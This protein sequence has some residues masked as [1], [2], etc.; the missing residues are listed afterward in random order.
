VGNYGTRQSYEKSVATLSSTEMM[1]HSNE[2][3]MKDVVFDPQEILALFA[4]TESQ[5]KGETL[6]LREIHSM[7]Q[8][9]F[10]VVETT[11]PIHKASHANTQNYDNP[12]NYD[13]ST[14]IGENEGKVDVILDMKD[15]DMIE[16]DESSDALPEWLKNDLEDANA[17]HPV[18]QG[19]QKENNERG[20]R[21]SKQKVQ[22]RKDKERKSNDKHQGVR[23]AR[24]RE[25][26]VQKDI[27]DSEKDKYIERLEKDYNRKR[28]DLLL[29]AENA[30][31]VREE[32]FNEE[33]IRLNQELDRHKQI[34]RDQLELKK[35]PSLSAAS[36]KKSTGIQEEDK[37][38]KSKENISTENDH[39]KGNGCIIQ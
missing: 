29:E 23:D 21:Q 7:N 31:R 20:S 37:T 4:S 27:T 34:Q 8:N 13:F 19:R 10:I 30:V 24:N 6:M 35:K 9:I 18:Q 14:P 36:M 26:N 3:A 11:C 17:D 5:A 15:H 32:A 22:S 1:R 12:T 33:L 28:K 16:M 38:H 25:E 39:A 2:I